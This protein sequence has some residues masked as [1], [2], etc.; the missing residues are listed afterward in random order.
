L[1]PKAYGH[2]EV[3]SELL[4]YSKLI[5]TRAFLAFAVVLVVNFVYFV[6]YCVSVGRVFIFPISDYFYFDVRG[7]T[8]SGSLYTANW[9]LMICVMATQ[10]SLQEMCVNW[11]SV[12]RT[13]AMFVLLNV[14]GTVTSLPIMYPLISVLNWSYYFR[15]KSRVAFFVGNGL[16]IDS[17]SDKN[18]KFLRRIA[19]NHFLSRLCF[20]I[21]RY[22]LRKKG[23]EVNNV[24]VY[25]RVH[26]A[27]DRRLPVID[28]LRAESIYRESVCSELDCLRLWHRVT[29]RLYAV[30]INV[31][32]V[33]LLFFS[34]DLS[35]YRDHRV[36]FV[37]FAA[38]LALEAM[39]GAMIFLWSLC[40]HRLGAIKQNDLR[41]RFYFI[42]LRSPE[43][44]RIH[45]IVFEHLLS[46]CN[47]FYKVWKFAIEH[48][49]TRQIL[50]ESEI[51]SVA[52]TV[53]DHIFEIKKV[54][55][56]LDIDPELWRKITVELDKD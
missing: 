37:A 29:F 21:Q 20:K 11:K 15:F 48:P 52:D 45:D 4:D 50:R 44:G 16:R 1:L 30:A 47:R 54:D 42:V 36:L 32:L 25:Q 2:H 26:Q 14:F 8:L 39:A 55:D 3:D 33:R 46:E 38:K 28:G 56:A 13:L 10:I 35:L 31:S 43:F 40:D 5:N 34:D 27:L 23:L 41:T 19:V 24:T 12:G 53:C 18:D 7:D 9:V 51:Y 6:M 22:S 17:A 49:A